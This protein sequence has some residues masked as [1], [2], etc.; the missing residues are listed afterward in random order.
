MSTALY[1]APD[2]VVTLFIPTQAIVD[3]LD[4]ILGLLC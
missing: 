1:N 3:V 2:L 4:I